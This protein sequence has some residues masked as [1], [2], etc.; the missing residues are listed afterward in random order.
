MEKKKS[1]KA[2]LEKSKSTFLFIGLILASSLLIFAFNWRS[3]VTVKIDG[4]SE[5]FIEE[6]FTK[7]T[8]PKDKEKEKPVS[9]PPPKKIVAESILIKPDTSEIKE[10]PIWLPE[11]SIIELDPIIEKG[12]V[13]YISPQVNAKFPG[14]IEGLRL[15]IAKHLDYPV[16]AV[17]NNIQ[18][19]VYLR[20]EVTKYGTIGKIEIFNKDEDELLKK[21]ALD[22]IKKLPKFKP[23]MQNGENVS[24]W[25]SIPISFK[26]N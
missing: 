5:S 16:Q 24:V 11:D 26:L 8:R 21:A 2:N 25:Y 6:D 4:N 3:Q 15:Y 9:K 22:V 1:F 18:G 12:P 13:I 17:E 7:I 19:T 23:G 14:G 10:V 20:F